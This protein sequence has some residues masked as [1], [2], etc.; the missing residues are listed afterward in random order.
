MSENHGVRI[1]VLL[2]FLG[3]V[4]QCE[5]CGHGIRFFGQIYDHG[6]RNPCFSLGS[7]GLGFGGFKIS[8]RIFFTKKHI[9]AL[10]CL[11]GRLNATLCIYSR[12]VIN[13]IVLSITYKIGDIFYSLSD[14]NKLSTPLGLL[15]FCFC[16]IQ[17]LSMPH[18]VSFA[19]NSTN[20]GNNVKQP[21]LF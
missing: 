3:F 11:V 2:S 7:N 20:S 18:F 21:H 9:W 13:K 6:F 10:Q 12:A 4:P 8:V 5:K 17:F 1:R 14:T 15:V 16:E 19:A